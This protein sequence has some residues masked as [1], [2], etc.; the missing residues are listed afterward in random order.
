MDARRLSDK[1]SDAC[2]YGLLVR[3]QG[4]DVVILRDP[5]KWGRQIFDE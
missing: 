2:F 3:G 4:R 1:I 5:A